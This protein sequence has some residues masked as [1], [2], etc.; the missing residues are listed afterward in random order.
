MAQV[1]GESGRYASQQ[2]VKKRGQG[3]IIALLGMGTIWLICGISIGLLLPS[4]LQ[5]LRVPAWGS[6][7]VCLVAGVASIGICRWIFPKLDELEKERANWQ[8][9]ANGEDMVAH[10]LERFPEEFKVI[11]DLTTPFGNLDHVVVGPTGVFILETKNWRGVVRADGQGELL[12]NDQPTDK[13]YV[14]R[15]LGR[16][17]DIKGKVEVLAPG[18]N[19]YFQAVFVFTSA[20]V[21]AHWGT[22]KS[23][24]CI[25]D[26]QIFDYIVE[27]K[28]G[29]KLTKQ[30][31]EK[32]ARAFFG[33]AHMDADFTKRVEGNV[34]PRI[35]AIVQRRDDRAN[36]SQVRLMPSLG[37]SRR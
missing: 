34:R 2:A 35:S 3:F 7:V 33:L 37:R 16:L 17:M 28:Q 14:R 29:V 13:P 21:D 25:R 12:W 32:I 24:N 20:R 9:G 19:P 4:V 10:E 26:E 11:N 36:P 5:N 31:V 6:G 30:A 18:L 15:F 22:T 23:V 8:R 27:S 1:L